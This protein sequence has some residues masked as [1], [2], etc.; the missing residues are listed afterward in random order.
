MIGDTVNV[1]HI[2][3]VAPTPAPHPLHRVP[4]TTPP[5]PRSSPRPQARTIREFD[6]RYTA[7]AFGYGSCTEYY[8]A[9]SPSGSLHRIRVPTLCLNAADDPFSPLHGERGWEGP[10]PPPSVVGRADPRVPPA[11]IPVAAA[12]HLPHV[13]LLVTS[14]GGHIGFLEGLLP[15][16]GGLM[17]RLFLQFVT[18]VFQH[19]DELRGLQDEGAAQGVSA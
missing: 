2:L 3:K 8:R 7:P 10:C 11:A 12:W 18:A 13:A 16:H 6:E 1:E 9:A 17:E 4:P 15:L 19:R 5:S 14:R